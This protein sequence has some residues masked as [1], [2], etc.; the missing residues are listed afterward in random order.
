MNIREKKKNEAKSILLQNCLLYESLYICLL[1]QKMICRIYFI[2]VNN[3]FLTCISII[4]QAYMNRCKCY[5][6]LF[7]IQNLFICSRN[8]MYLEKI[9]KI[10]YKKNNIYY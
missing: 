1:R 4:N 10:W 2:L 5:E 8:K 9:N 3:A 6:T 7:F